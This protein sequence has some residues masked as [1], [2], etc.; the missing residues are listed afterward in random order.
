MMECLGYILV[1]FLCWLVNITIIYKLVMI[2]AKRDL[3]KIKDQIMEE[4]REMILNEIK[5]KG[6]HNVND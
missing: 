2:F 4:S 1:W 3:N 5:E 6:I